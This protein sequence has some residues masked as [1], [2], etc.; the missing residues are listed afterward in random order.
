VRFRRLVALTSLGLVAL[1]IAPPADAQDFD[2][3]GRKKPGGKPTAPGGRPAQPGG[4]PPAPGGRPTAPAPGGRPAPGTNPDVGQSQTVLIDR[5]TKIVISQP[6]SP[7]PL[8]RLAQL[9]R[10]KD[11]N[12]AGL[13]KDFEARAAQAG[14]E[15]YAS[16]V[17]SSSRASRRSTVARTTRSAPTRRPSR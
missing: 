4:R 16:T 15:Q 10:D 9:Y 5:Y 7:F 6:G 12:L 3:R 14:A 13:V 8:Q 2:P 17:R 11:G 1:L